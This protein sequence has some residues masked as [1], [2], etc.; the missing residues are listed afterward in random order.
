MTTL[1]QI[2]GKYYGT[3]HFVKKAEDLKELLNVRDRQNAEH[4]FP[5]NFIIERIID[6]NLME[7]EGFCM[8]LLETEPFIKENRDL[9]YIE[10]GTWHCILVRAESADPENMD[11]VLIECEGYDWAR[12]SAALGDAA[13][14]TIFNK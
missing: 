12:Y 9:M 14:G 13:S 10:N 3:A 6:L 7:Y 1:K 8:E 11:G 5:Q 4:K 2:N